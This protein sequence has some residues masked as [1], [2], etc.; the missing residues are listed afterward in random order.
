ME[1]TEKSPEDIR[2]EAE[3]DETIRRAEEIR[4][5]TPAL[6]ESDMVRLPDE[7]NEV[8]RGEEDVAEGESKMREELRFQGKIIYI[9]DD[10]T[11]DLEVWRGGKP[12]GLRRLKHGDL[13]YN[14][15]RAGIYK[16]HPDWAG[17]RFW[18]DNLKTLVL[19]GPVEAVANRP[20]EES[21]EPSSLGRRSEESDEEYEQRL[22]RELAEL[23]SEEPVSDAIRSPSSGKTTKNQESIGGEFNLEYGGIRY[24]ID[25]DG[26]ARVYLPPKDGKDRPPRLVTDGNTHRFKDADGIWKP[27]AWH[28]AE[29]KWVVVATDKATPLDKEKSKDKDQE[30]PLD[31][32]GRTAMEDLLK[33]MGFAPRSAKAE[34][35]E[36]IR[37][38]KHQITKAKLENELAG[39]RPAAKPE[40]A[41]SV[42]K[43]NP[44]LDAW[45]FS[46]HPKFNERGERMDAA[47][48]ARSEGLRNGLSEERQVNKAKY[49]YE[50]AEKWKKFPLWGKLGVSLSILGAGVAGSVFSPALAAVSA[51]G[52]LAWRSI[53]AVGAG[54]LM[55]TTTVTYLKKRNARHPWLWGALAGLGVGATAF[56]SKYLAEYIN[57]IAPAAETISVPEGTPEVHWT[58]DTETMVGTPLFPGGDLDAAFDKF[59][60]ASDGPLKGFELS[61]G[62]Q[63]ELRDGLKMAILDD[64]PKLANAFMNRVPEAVEKA[65]TDILDTA[66]MSGDPLRWSAFGDPA[67]AAVIKDFLTMYGTEH[68]VPELESKGGVEGLV[69]RL[70]EV[71]AKK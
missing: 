8:D 51:I 1:G 53:A 10:N 45:E 6:Q 52:A 43:E 44:K 37:D 71:F 70:Q 12:A 41:P 27:H 19:K 48:R 4:A 33:K 49:F 54:A 16:R 7:E 36:D 28:K 68:L 20:K 26:N 15:P 17:E 13:V 69:A 22:E 38:L 47:L 2:R 31:K 42:K 14:D 40:E 34:E 58:G 62:A 35:P 24:G 11:A 59:M 56:G 66:V 60:L 23:K 18:D 30:P 9:N 29:K 50:I 39:L 46:D 61:P 67:H 32:L 25:D 64:N 63:A 65:G 3:L 21:S 5:S 57:T 55:S